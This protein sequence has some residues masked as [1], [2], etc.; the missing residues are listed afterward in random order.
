MIYIKHGTY[1]DHEHYS[2]PGDRRCEPTWLARACRYRRFDYRRGA[3]ESRRSGTPGE[4]SVVMNR[5][6]DDLE[7]L[8]RQP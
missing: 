1:P 8:R 2:V 5:I 7:L 6:N 3:G 4:R